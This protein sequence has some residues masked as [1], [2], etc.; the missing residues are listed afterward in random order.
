LI[1]LKINPEEK[2][3]PLCITWTS[4][5]CISWLLPFIGHT[6][7]G[8]VQGEIHDFAGP[9]YVSVND[10]AFGSTLKYVK[11]NVTAD[12]YTKFNESIQSADKTYRKRNHNICCDN[13]HSHV[14]KALNN[15]NYQGRSNYTMINVWFMLICK[16]RYVSWSAVLFTYIGWLIIG[17]IA[18]V[19]YLI[20]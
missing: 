19:I 12:Q 1:D 2:R 17:A 11:L 13:C 15:F 20:S 16:G 4:I 9:Y 6:G 8:T 18:L 10:F 3:F 14:A 7:I 5:P